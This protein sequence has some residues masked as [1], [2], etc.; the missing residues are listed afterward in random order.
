MWRFKRR[1]RWKE[2]PDRTKIYTEPQIRKRIEID[3]FQLYPVHPSSG[4][5][6]SPPF[7]LIFV[8]SQLAS[9]GA[10]I[11]MLRNFLTLSIP[12]FFLK[13]IRLIITHSPIVWFPQ[14]IPL[15]FDISGCSTQLTSPFPSNL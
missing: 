14:D 2:G 4:P 12:M 3:A 7:P 1:L 10:E 6:R 9:P 15:S 11:Y 8:G 5:S 13:P